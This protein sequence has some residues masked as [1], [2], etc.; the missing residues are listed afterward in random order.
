MRHVALSLLLAAIAIRAEEAMPT[1]DEFSKFVMAVV[2]TYPTDGTHGYYWPKGDAWPGTT[3]DLLYQGTKACEADPQKRCYC[4]GLTFEVFA[5]AWKQWGEGRKREFAI[6]GVDGKGILDL[7][8]DWFGST[9]DKRTTLQAAVVSRKLGRAIAN[10]DE[11]RAGDFVQL[12]R[13][14]GTGHSVVFL[15][16]K[17]GGDGKV[18]GI[19]YWST[20]KSTNGIGEREERVAGDDGVDLEQVYV[21]RVGKR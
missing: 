3:C 21:V 18:K 14:N 4:C 5:K 13:K 1:E 19:K 20:Q 16:W 15:E 10:P 2:K 8:A 17:K 11:A 6:P 9:G 7:R 12:W